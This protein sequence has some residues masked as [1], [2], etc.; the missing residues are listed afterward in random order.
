VCRRAPHCPKRPHWRVRTANGLP[1]LTP[2]TATR[3][4]LRRC[5]SAFCLCAIG[6]H[7]QAAALRGQEF[8]REI[9]RAERNCWCT[10][11]QELD[12]GTS[13]ERSQ[14]R[15]AVFVQSNGINKT[16]RPKTAQQAAQ[17]SRKCAAIASKLLDL[18]DQVPATRRHHTKRSPIADLD[19]AGRPLDAPA[20]LLG[21][22]KGALHFLVKN[23]EKARATDRLRARLGDIGGT[24]AGAKHTANRLF[25]PICFQP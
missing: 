10:A 8:R 9:S 7:R 20:I 19:R 15:V 14:G 22:L 25:N 5:F 12:L 4:R 2:Q 17:Q 24:E 3:N 1:K 11:W 23:L 13:A 6:E 16:P 21:V 18:A